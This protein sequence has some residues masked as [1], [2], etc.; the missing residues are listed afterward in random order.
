MMLSGLVEVV[1]S[2]PY[3]VEFVVCVPVARPS[4]GC[5]GYGRGRPPGHP[6][7]SAASNA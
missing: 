6:E 1:N 2:L 5:A 7:P 4:W 3:L